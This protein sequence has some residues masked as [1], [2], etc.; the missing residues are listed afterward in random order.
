MVAGSIFEAPRNNNNNNNN[1]PQVVKLD[2]AALE[3]IQA[4]MEAVVRRMVPL[5]MVKENDMQT[6]PAKM[7]TDD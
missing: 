5:D 3:A 2:N 7:D 4:M 6:A 1:E